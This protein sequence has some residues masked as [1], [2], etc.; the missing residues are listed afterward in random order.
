[1]R[2]KLTRAQASSSRA[3]PQ[4]DS[5]SKADRQVNSLLHT[6]RGEQFRHS[7]NVSKSKIRISNELGYKL[8]TLP[9]SQIFGEANGNDIAPVQP[10]PFRAPDEPGHRPRNRPPITLIEG[11]PTYAYPNGAVPGPAPPKSWSAL[12]DRD[13]LDERDTS[14]WRRN[15]LSLFFSHVP[16]PSARPD[17]SIPSLSNL[18]M[19]VLLKYCPSPE[20]LSECAPF[21]SPHLR[22]DFIRWCAIHLPLP[23][24]KLHALCSDVG[25]ADGE[26]IIVGPEASFRLDRIRRPQGKKWVNP[27][28][29]AEEEE[30]WDIESFDQNEEHVPAQEEDEDWDRASSDLPPPLVSLVLLRTHLSVPSALPPTLTHVALLAFPRP[31]HIHHLPP[32]CPLIEVL[33]LSF[34]GWLSESSGEGT[35]DRIEWKR[36][37]NLRVLGLRDCGITVGKAARINEQRWTDVEIIGMQEV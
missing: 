22:R 21:I 28:A 11:V 34:N 15:A 8:P 25:H 32:V 18:C 12:F 14:E 7:Q 33:D 16:L 24:A 3:D 2:G 37:R 9:L 5:S 4:E 31:I 10:A 26:L 35:F 17:S 23:M 29:L 19:R 27:S 1:M 13:R 30:E 20:D 6:L 36:W